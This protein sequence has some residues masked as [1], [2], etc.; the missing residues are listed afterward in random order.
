MWWVQRGYKT[1]NVG[2]RKTSILSMWVAAKLA[3][4][5]PMAASDNNQTGLY[6]F[7]RILHTGFFS[8][9]KMTFVWISW[10]VRPL[11]MMTLIRSDFICGN[12]AAQV[13]CNLIAAVRAC[14]RACS[15]YCPKRHSKPQAIP[16]RSQLRDL[17]SL[18]GHHQPDK[19]QL[20]ACEKSETTRKNCP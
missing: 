12:S 1:K 13:L 15:A 8:A 2:G 19:D 4:Y 14:D 3:F 5:Y 6:V 10:R 11:A 18:P 7:V 9:L 17:P 20:R 16:V